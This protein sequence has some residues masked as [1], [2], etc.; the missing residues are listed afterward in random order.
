MLDGVGAELAASLAERP[1]CGDWTHSGVKGDPSGKGLIVLLGPRTSTAAKIADA[2]RSDQ[3]KTNESVVVWTGMETAASEPSFGVSMY[4]Q[5]SAPGFRMT[6]ALAFPGSGVLPGTGLDT[7]T[8]QY[9]QDYV[10]RWNVVL[11]ALSE[12]KSQLRGRLAALARNQ[13]V[14]DRIELSLVAVGFH[15]AYK[16]ELGDTKA[17]LTPVPRWQ[18]KTHEYSHESTP[19]ISLDRL[20]GLDVDAPGGWPDEP[21]W[22]WP[23][24]PAWDSAHWPDEPR[25]RRQRWKEMAQTVRKPAYAVRVNPARCAELLEFPADEAIRLLALDIADLL[26]LPE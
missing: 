2:G 15:Q 16:P 17:D 26:G 1:G 21:F 3:V 7:N 20:S 25:A 24:A 12:K 23:R 19:P 18:G 8:D 10:A 13:H 4:R 14:S 22:V 5:A 9:H 6:P 11:E